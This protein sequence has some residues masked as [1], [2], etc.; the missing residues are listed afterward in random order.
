MKKYDHIYY[1]QNEII[2]PGRLLDVTLTDEGIIYFVENLTNHTLDTTKNIFKAHPVSDNEDRMT[3]D[4]YIEALREGYISDYDG[5]GDLG[6]ESY[7]YASAPTWTSE[8]AVAQLKKV[9]TYCPYVY[10][11]NK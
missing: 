10:W 4:E 1:Y 3:I 9:A 6:D 5:S 7:R 11:F 8:S 2:I